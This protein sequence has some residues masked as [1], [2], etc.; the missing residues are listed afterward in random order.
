MGSFSPEKPKKP[1]G[2]SKPKREKSP[3]NQGVSTAQLRKEI[4]E[5]RYTMPHH[6]RFFS[7]QD[8]ERMIK[9][10]FAKYGNRIPN[11]AEKEVI[12]QLQREGQKRGGPEGGRIER[13]SRWLKE[14]R[15]KRLRGR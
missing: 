5:S 7:R 3:G 11:Y 9:E 10:Y 13:M 12:R 2:N 4:M 15:E 14:V 1:T 8:A 6:G